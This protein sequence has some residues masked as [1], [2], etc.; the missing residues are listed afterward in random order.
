MPA[1]NTPPA[2]RVFIGLPTYNGE[3]VAEAVP[4][5]IQASKSAE[6]LTFQSRRRSL[7]CFGFNELWVIALNSRAEQRWTHFAMHHADIEAAPWWLDTLLDEMDRVGADV[8]STVVPM[9]DHRGLTSTGYFDDD[10]QIHRLTMHELYK[11]PETFSADNL[12]GR[13][14]AINTGLWV[15]RF[16]EDWVEKIHFR[17]RDGISKRPDGS[18]FANVL[19][20]DWDMSAQLADLGLKVFATRK[21]AVRHYGGNASFTNAEPWGEWQTDQGHDGVVEMPAE[22]SAATEKQEPAS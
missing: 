7:L 21:V 3:F 1:S 6:R 5:L 2:R 20:E 18:F 12:P 10:M 13:P 11:L 22:M 9:K 19:S 17:I 15:A 14:L 8:L 16:T 4:G